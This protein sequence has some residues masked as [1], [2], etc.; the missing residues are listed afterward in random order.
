MAN[1]TLAEATELVDNGTILRRLEDEVYQF[2]KFSGHL[3]GAY[4]EC[5]TPNQH[6]LGL[7]ADTTMEEAQTAFITHFQEEEHKATP[8]TIEDSTDW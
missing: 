6:D 2:H 8:P 5:C 7:D 1:L 4:Y 3:D